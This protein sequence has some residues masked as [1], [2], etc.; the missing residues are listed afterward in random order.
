MITSTGNNF[1][2]GE[3]RFKDHQT[4]TM[5]I[6][7]G[8]FTADA[9]C[10][11]YRSA[12]VLEIHV[13][14][15]PISRSTEVPAYMVGHAEDSYGTMQPRGT[16]VKTWI[17]DRNT[18]CIEKISDWDIGPE[19]TYYFALA[20]AA[21]GI[22]TEYHR[23]GNVTLT[24]TDTTAEGQWSLSTQGNCIVRDSWV[25]CCAPFDDLCTTE[26]GVP[27]SFRLEGLPEDIELDL[28]MVG[29]DSSTDRD[30]N[31]MPEFHIKG[32]L[33][34]SET[35][36]PKGINHQNGGQFFHFFAVR[37]GQTTETNV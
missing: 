14:D 22:R 10:E 23:E 15:L 29:S 16:T 26:D 34:T 35:G 36:L 28:P 4:A 9:S 11:A 1:G 6:L 8:K 17:K 25:F 18:I 30:G 24:L 31:A 5:V 37:D 20:Y 7:N 33:F 3:I 27:F 21:L 12:D 13:P 2:A 32:S 19:L